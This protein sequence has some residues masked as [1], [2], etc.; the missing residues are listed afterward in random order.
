MKT[1][2]IIAAVAFF[3]NIAAFGQDGR[4]TT[5]ISNAKNNS[6]I[7]Y[8]SDGSV[9]SI[10]N[11]GKIEF[12]YQWI[13]TADTVSFADQIAHWDITSLRN[14]YNTYRDV[15]IN[16]DEQINKCHLIAKRYRELNMEIKNDSM[17]MAHL[18]N[19]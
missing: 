1:K 10:I 11:I 8:H 12:Y 7:E 2:L 5:N 3:Y 16:F 18:S 19:H 15:K 6:G 9:K 4:I 14:Y 17:Q 13:K